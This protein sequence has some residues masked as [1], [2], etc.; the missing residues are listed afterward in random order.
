MQI[1]LTSS[2]PSELCC[3]HVCPQ[4]PTEFLTH[5]AVDPNSGLEN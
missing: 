1:K 5:K 3:F 4:R 2:D